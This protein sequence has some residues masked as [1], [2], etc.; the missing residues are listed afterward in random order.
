MSILPIYTFDHPV[1]RQETSQVEEDSAEISG[2]IV[3]MF[4]TMNNARGIGLA[5]NQVGKSLALTV[6][7]VS[8]F[9]GFEDF[10]PMVLINPVILGTHGE[11]VFEEGCLSLPDI[12]EDIVRPES[13][14]VKFHDASF[15]EV[16]MEV[17]QI[18]ARVIQ[19]EIDHLHGKYFIDYLSPL[20]LSLLKGRLSRMHRG[21]LEVDY[22]IAP[23]H[24]EAKQKS[25]RKPR[26]S[27]M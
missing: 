7:D 11:S 25:S 3:S 10:K 14:G 21:E 26:L 24:V 5:A 12:R 18:L 2:L 6:I 23:P 17:N 15:K 8:D 9:E 27:R 20:K 1:L 22:P 16:E 13:V 4:E 19:H